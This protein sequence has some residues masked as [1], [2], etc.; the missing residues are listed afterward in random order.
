MSQYAD[1]YIQPIYKKKE[2]EDLKK[3]REVQNLAHLP[4][5]ASLNDQTCSLNQDDLVKYVDVI[6]N[7]HCHAHLCILAVL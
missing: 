7:V 1:Y 3:S 5:R 4:T 2:Q 6:G